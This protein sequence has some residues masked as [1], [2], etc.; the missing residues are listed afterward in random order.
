[1]LGYFPKGLLPQTKSVQNRELNQASPKYP[2]KI[3]PNVFIQ[4]LI[5][6]E[7]YI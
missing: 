5:L 7:E 6:Q 2:Y 3:K 1:M 4:A